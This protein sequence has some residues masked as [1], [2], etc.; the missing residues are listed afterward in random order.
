MP[1]DSRRSTRVPLK[2]AIEVIG[3]DTQ[4]HGDGETIVVNIHGG[5]IA[6]TIGLTVGMKIS[7]Q[8]LLTNKRANARVVGVDLVDMLHCGV[9]WSSQETYGACRYRPT[10]GKRHPQNI[11]ASESATSGLTELPSQELHLIH[12]QGGQCI[13]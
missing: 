9:G 2:V 5:L 8:V 11:S 4:L 6:T 13:T 1:G 12:L 10:I 7:I 3:G